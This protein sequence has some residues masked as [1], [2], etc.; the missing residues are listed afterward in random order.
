MKPIYG[1]GH[2]L[3]AAFFDLFYRGEVAGTEWI[4]REG[5]FILA[6]NHASFL[7]PPAIGCRVPR[8]IHYFAR[9]TLFK[10]PLFGKLLH[11]LNT[12]P[13][14]LESDSDITALKTVFRVLGEGGGILLFP[15]GTR[16][17]TGELQPARSGVGMIACKSKVP[18]VPAR[19]F[20]TF[21]AFGR[22]QRYPRFNLPVDVAFAPPLSF[23]DYNVEGKG[24]ERYQAVSEKIMAAIARIPPPPQELV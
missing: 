16:T 1:A 22:T 14:D 13:V 20:G 6:V 3:S 17:P 10:H 11:S 4:P 19:L 24:K 7:D 12:I 15:E 23:A 5:P 21:E 2:A 8:E 18:V 9:K